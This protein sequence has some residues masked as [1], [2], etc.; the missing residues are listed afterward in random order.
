MNKDTLQSLGLFW[1]RVIVGFSI[2]SHGYGKVF[3]GH[4]AEFAKGVGAMGFPVPIVF[5]WAAALSEL[6]GGILIAF[7]LRIRY[8]AFFVF[9]TMSVAIFIHHAPDPFKVKELAVLYW[10]AA[11]A[12]MLTGAGRYALDRS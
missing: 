10:A 11:G 7:G 9:F 6:L 2:A 8:A 1:L 5:A 12:L 4:I 3:G